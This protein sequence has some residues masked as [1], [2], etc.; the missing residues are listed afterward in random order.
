MTLAAIMVH[1]DF[2]EETADRIGVAIWLAGRFNSLLIGVAGWP[3]RKYR[4]ME[5]SAM[6]FPPVEEARHEKIL[7]HLERLGE[8]FRR[9]AGAIAGGAYGRT[10]L[11]EW[12]VGAVTRHL[13][14]TN[15]V[16]C[17]FSN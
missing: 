16:P 4:A 3:L 13:L 17:L 6:E 5:R 11:S 8:K 7:E 2:D 14:T 9:S 15:A 10:R 12:T 1:V